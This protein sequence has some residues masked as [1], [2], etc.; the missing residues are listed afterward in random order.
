[1]TNKK[2][3]NVSFPTFLKSVFIGA[4][5]LTLTAGC[6]GNMTQYTGIEQ[7]NRNEVELV[8]IPFNIQFPQNQV[9]L[10]GREIVKLNNFLNTADVTYGDEFSMDFPLDRNGNLSELDKQ[11]LVYISNLL[12][13]SGLYMSEAITPYGMEPTAGTG[14]LLI[15]K[16]VV[17]TPDCG[18]WSQK[19]Y[20]NYENAPL[21]NLGCAN[22]AN[23]GLMV[24]NPRDL[25]IG[26]EG[27]PASAE[28]SAG[29]VERYRSRTVVVETAST[30]G[31]TGN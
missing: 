25:I 17:S 11:R 4:T 24:A 7:Q 10:D 28:R 30:T 26:A 9:E 2:N 16:Y 20:P 5:C 27:A 14:R 31:N 8:R 18:D 19:S 21:N 22:Q 6:A 3:M 12:K 23:L 1:M 29:A 15:S 13:E